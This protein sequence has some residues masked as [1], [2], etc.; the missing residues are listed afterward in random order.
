MKFGMKNK[1]KQ[2]DDFIEN[3]K[4]K[5]KGEIEFMI[6]GPNDKGFC[7]FSLERDSGTTVTVKGSLFNAKA[8]MS[9]ECNGEVIKDK[10]FGLQ[11]SANSIYEVLPS[12][13]P[14]VAKYLSDT[15]GGVGLALAKT[16]VKAH[17]PDGVFEVLDDDP[18]KLLDLKGIGKKKL[19]KIVE[20]WREARASYRVMI[21]LRGIGIGPEL[22]NRAFITLGGPEGNDVKGLIEQNPY[23]LT[24]VPGIGFGKADMAALKLGI[25]PDS[26]FR[27]EACAH[28][29]LDTSTSEGHTYMTFTDLGRAIRTLTNARSR[30]I[31]HVIE[32]ATHNPDVIEIP[33]YG[34]TEGWDR[35]LML[36]ALYGCE[37]GIAHHLKRIACG[38]GLLTDV[39]EKRLSQ[40]PFPLHD[41]QK[42]AIRT[43]LTSKVSVLTGGPGMGKTTIVKFIVDMAKERDANI[44]LVAPT[45]RAAKQ[46]ADATGHEA[47]TVHSALGLGGEDQVPEEGLKCDVAIMDETSMTDTYLMFQFLKALPSNAIVLLVGDVDQLPSVGP[48]N[49]LGDFIDS[50]MIPVSRLTKVYRT[51]EGSGV[52]VA[53]SNIIRGVFPEFTNDF[54]LTQKNSQ[55][56]IADTIVQR[57]VDAIVSGVPRDEVQVLSPV[58]KGVIGVIELNKRLQNTLNPEQKDSPT[59]TAGDYTFR[60]NDRVLQVKNNKE[61]GIVN[62]D[63]GVIKDIVDDGSRSK[64]IVDF[65]GDTVEIPR[66]G[67]INLNLA[68][69][70]T[71]HKSQG[72]QFRYIIMPMSTSHN[73]NNML[74]RNL[75]YTGITRAKEDV[76]L[77]GTATALKIAI[78][79][80]MNRT[81]KTG[82][83]ECLLSMAA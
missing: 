27:I 43:A 28:H 22:A 17:G 56:D 44:L 4:M 42:N 65:E 32:Q 69:V 1:V 54:R 39:S 64:I 77:I 46:L 30:T 13:A 62:G 55:E 10:K 80:E 37:K 53:A 2:D 6:F 51:G 61:L 14:G 38:S 40:T 33:Y 7:I 26:P 48:G 41:K 31:A 25:P 23:V 58:K 29:C 81:R 57:V 82:L 78:K 16:M 8:G 12:D 75:V 20:D 9:V 71:V 36:P 11:F 76:E 21:Y 47:S 34:E 66:A 24:H 18:E 68:Y 3:T 83:K 50:G 59:I 60:I 72:G 67:F 45:G 52:A 74:N 19:E 5:L 63:L 15:L 73:F 49:V 70:M 79:N 35:W